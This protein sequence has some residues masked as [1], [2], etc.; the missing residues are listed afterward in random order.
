[1]SYRYIATTPEGLVQQVAVS[2]LR[3]GYWWYV[4]G[5]IPDHKDPELTDQKL[6]TRYEI[7]ITERQRAYRKQQGL[8][9]MQYIRYGRWFV[10]LI[11]EGHHAFRQQEREQIRDCRRHPVHFEGYSLSYR[12]G[13]ATPKGGG[14]P[15][16]HACVRIEPTTAKQLK[17][18]FM[19]RACHR[20]AE[21]LTD[22][23]R[24]VPYA[25]Y[26]PVRRQLLNI[27]RAVNRARIQAGFEPVPVAALNLRRKIT[28]P[29]SDPEIVSSTNSASPPP[30][31]PPTINRS[32]QECA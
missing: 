22:D 28:K 32:I 27:H 9:N 19:K 5:R 21:H 23:F 30:V 10:L 3:H 15:K 6:L 25:R 12:R 8:A 16:W 29:F 24:R 14:E 31:E 11:T 4:T 26:A 7:A 1:M 2:Y 18:Y 13:G 20:T 17:A